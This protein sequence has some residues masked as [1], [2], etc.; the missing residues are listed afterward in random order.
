MDWSYKFGPNYIP[1]HDKKLCFEDD[2]TINHW[3]EQWYLSY[4]HCFN[5]HK[6]M[7]TYILFVMRSFVILKSIGQKY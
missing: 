6:K 7:K 3:L 1:I 5:D 2:L 4:K